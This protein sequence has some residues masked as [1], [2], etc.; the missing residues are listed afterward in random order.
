VIRLAKKKFQ[1]IGLDGTRIDIDGKWYKSLEYYVINKMP[2][3]GTRMYNYLV[4]S[5]L[6]RTLRG[7]G[8]IRIRLE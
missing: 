3:A 8:N 5:G 1:N 7:G 6:F 2:S 4:I